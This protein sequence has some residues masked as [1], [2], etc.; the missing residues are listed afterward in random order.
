LLLSD[1]GVAVIQGPEPIAT[2]DPADAADVTLDTIAYAPDGAVQLAGRGQGGGGLRLYLDNAPVM[3]AAVGADGAWAVTMPD[4]SPGLYTLRIDQLGSDGAVTS[5]FETPFKR[6][7]LAALAAAAG[8]PDAEERPAE[9][10][11]PIASITPYPPPVP[12]ITPVP[13]A[14]PEPVVTAEAGAEAVQ[15]DASAPPTAPVAAPVAAPVV[16]PAVE[17]EV[18]AIAPVPNLPEVVIAEPQDP[19]AVPAPDAIIPASPDPATAQVAP[20]VVAAA[21]PPVEKAPVTVTVQPGFTLWGIATD[22]FGEG[23]M[24][25]QVFEANRDRIKDPDL[26]YPGQVFTLPQE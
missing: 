1:E 15:P 14:A 9:P 6:E 5:R 26:I 24:Y 20:P 22:R 4:I 17:P 2:A 10:A 21:D 12:T 25:V 3:D 8:S 11:P 19:A 7:T 16:E 13:E 18:A 23:T